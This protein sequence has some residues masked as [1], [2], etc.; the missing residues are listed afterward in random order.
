MDLERGDRLWNFLPIISLHLF[1]YLIIP[2]T[3]LSTLKFSLTP[4]LIL[5][6]GKRIRILSHKNFCDLQA[7]TGPSD[8]RVVQKA[9]KSLQLEV[10]DK[11]NTQNFDAET[12]VKDHFVKQGQY[13]E[14]L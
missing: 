3:I 2:S 12:S 7:Y 9:A 13:A 8:F 6:T 14:D 10:C 5:I 11:E 1:Q 4:L